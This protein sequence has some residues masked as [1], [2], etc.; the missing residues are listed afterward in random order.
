MTRYFLNSA[1]AV[2]FLLANFSAEA[3]DPPGK[4]PT[5]GLETDLGTVKSRPRTSVIKDNGIMQELL[6]E[7]AS[8]W[9]ARLV[10]GAHPNASAPSATGNIAELS[11]ASSRSSSPELVPLE[12][13]AEIIPPKT[14][15]ETLVK[16]TDERIKELAH[17]YAIQE[18]EAALKNLES[19]AIKLKGKKG[20]NALTKAILANRTG[21]EESLAA[22]LKKTR[23]AIQQIHARKLA[24]T[25]NIE[26]PAASST[27]E[28]ATAE[29]PLFTPQEARQIG[30][31]WRLMGYKTESLQGPQGELTIG[32]APSEPVASEAPH[33]AE[34]GTA[35]GWVPYLKSYL[36]PSR[37][38]ESPPS[39]PNPVWGITFPPTLQ[40]STEYDAQEAEV[41]QN[42]VTQHLQ[43]ST[44]V[45]HW[46]HATARWF[47]NQGHTK[48]YKI[49]VEKNPLTPTEDES[50]GAV[51]YPPVTE[52]REYT[53]YDI[54][55]IFSKQVKTYI[56]DEVFV[57]N[58]KLH[59][60]DFLQ[61]H[62]V[63]AENLLGKEQF[64]LYFSER[65]LYIRSLKVHP[66]V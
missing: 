29:A 25:S 46:D 30:I 16:I 66:S 1:L 27:E 65:H 22:E 51:D 40:G 64:N 13:I 56:Q 58:W 49:I 36:Y 32:E 53:K 44:P 60:W 38:A 37:I 17:L 2:P 20:T 31:L 19:E 35:G 57:G 10:S 8:K 54:L 52:M 34:S 61:E 12:K 18:T 59:I 11:D 3:A 33:E 39:P 5:P 24:E 6:G 50:I 7:G 62:P 42:K 9:D 4:E 48:K 45:V 43:N 21:I 41:Y 23:E 14:W 55:D 63:I 26:E 15:F 47:W 28:Q